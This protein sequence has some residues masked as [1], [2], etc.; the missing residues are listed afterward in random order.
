MQNGKTKFSL[1]RSTLVFNRTF[2]QEQWSNGFSGAN[3]LSVF[4]FSPVHSLFNPFISISSSMPRKLYGFYCVIFAST[5]YREFTVFGVGRIKQNN[6]YILAKALMK[7]NPE[8]QPCVRHSC[9][10]YLSQVYSTVYCHTIYS[11]NYSYITISSW[12]WINPKWFNQTVNLLTRVNLVKSGYI[13]KHF[14]LIKH[15][16]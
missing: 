15:I 7:R 12:N 11:F 2:S 3:L 5:Y 8:T 6:W 4:H 10:Q 1:G 16:F 14:N 13:D 9:H